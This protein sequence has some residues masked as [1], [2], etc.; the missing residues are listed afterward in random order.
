MCYRAW[1][2]QASTQ[3]S[4]YFSKWATSQS[5]DYLFIGCADSRVP[6]SHQLFLSASFQITIMAEAGVMIVTR[7]SS[8]EGF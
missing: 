6:V 2:K 8:S 1:A 5:P 4:T 7:L 3:D